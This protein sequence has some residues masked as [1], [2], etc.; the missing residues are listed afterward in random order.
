MIQF[1]LEF[2][3]FNAQIANQL[4]SILDESISCILGDKESMI[5]CVKC[6]VR[7]INEQ[8]QTNSA[9]NFLIPRNHV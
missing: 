4:C 1:S 3:I 5:V 8:A 9:L 6:I 2:E 7:K